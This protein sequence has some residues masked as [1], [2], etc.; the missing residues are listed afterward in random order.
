VTLDH[1]NSRQAYLRFKKKNRHAY[2]AID[3]KCEALTT[4]EKLIGEFDGFKSKENN[5]SLV[6]PPFP[7]RRI[8]PELAPGAGTVRPL[9]AHNLAGGSECP[10][11]ASSGVRIRPASVADIRGMIALERDSPSA[12]HWPEPA[13]ARVFSADSATRI[14]IVAQ[15]REASV[16]GFAI[17][18]VVGEEVELENIV[19]DR[20][21]R[22]QGLGTKLVE[23]IMERSKSRNASRLFLE[24]RESNPAARALYE[25]CG[26][27][28]S[29]RRRA[30]YTSPSEDAVLYTR[31]VGKP[32][33]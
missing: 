9:P 26:F 31:K 20:K 8:S 17:A 15:D 22:K 19:V 11:Y 3:A 1:W 18:R 24:V 2:Q 27:V 7:S 16:R 5:S 25:K 29:G 21:R 32:V 23:K 14:A 33:A 28:L 10:P 12:A 30:Y 6:D 4:R 13:Y